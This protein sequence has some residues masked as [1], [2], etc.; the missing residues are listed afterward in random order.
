[1]KTDNKTTNVLLDLHTVFSELPVLFREWV[2]EECDYSTLAFYR[3]LRNVDQRINGKLIPALSEA[4]KA[5]I[6]VIAQLL[7]KA[8]VTVI[9]DDPE[10]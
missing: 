4:E 7:A 9:W 5:K 3:K 2:C 6:R 10:I 1:M 8:L